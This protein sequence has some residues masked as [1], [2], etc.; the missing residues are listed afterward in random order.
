MSN[1]GFDSIN[2]LEEQKLRSSLSQAFATVT[3]GKLVRFALLGDLHDRREFLFG[4]DS[5][6][7]RDIRSQDTNEKK[8]KILTHRFWSNLSVENIHVNEV[9]SKIAH[10]T[11]QNNYLLHFQL[12][13]IL[14]LISSTKKGC[15]FLALPKIDEI[16]TRAIHNTEVNSMNC[17]IIPVRYHQKSMSNY[18]YMSM[19]LNNLALNMISRGITPGPKLAGRCLKTAANRMQFE[20][21]QMYLEIFNKN[22]HPIPSNVRKAL[23]AFSRNLIRYQNPQNFEGMLESERAEI[24]RLSLQIITGWENDGI[25]S[26]SESRKTSFGVLTRSKSPDQDFSCISLFI[27]F[28]YVLADLGLVRALKHE[29]RSLPDLSRSR[30][31]SCLFATA[32][33]V[34]REP[35]I[36]LSILEY[37]FEL[38]ACEQNSEASFLEGLKGVDMSHSNFRISHIFLAL[39][40]HYRLKTT[41]NIRNKLESIKLPGSPREILE[42]LVEFIPPRPTIKPMTSS[43]QGSHYLIYK[44]TNNAL[45]EEDLLIE[46]TRDVYGEVGLL[47]STEGGKQPLHWRPASL[48]RRQ[49]YGALNAQ[50]T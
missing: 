10:L 33:L 7:M 23:T 42:T 43:R 21:I 20:L 12:S 16:M 31:I 49:L 1:Q 26:L 11:E 48:S 9:L 14:S 45:H 8:I 34:A 24:K 25:P 2:Y 39:Y 41:L 30:Y 47:V 40:T 28:I 46:W 36:A 3:P 32:F 4:R 6:L 35:H 37:H 17:S 50:G 15:S 13:H 5:T 44:H 22:K 18:V 19:N 38:S 27:T 29:W